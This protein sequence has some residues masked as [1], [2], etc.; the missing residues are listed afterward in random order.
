MSKLDS[1]KPQRYAPVRLKEQELAPF[2]NAL[3]NRELVLGDDVS[4]IKVSDKP[5]QATHTIQ[6]DLSEIGSGSKKTTT[7]RSKSANPLP[8]VSKTSP[9]KKAK[10]A[11][12]RKLKKAKL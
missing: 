5:F 3:K 8:G 2:F 6:R 11:I 4:S 7:K 1:V 12:E 9:K 10:V